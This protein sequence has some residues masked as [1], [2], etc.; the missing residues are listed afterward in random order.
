MK[1]GISKIH[2]LF[3]IPDLLFVPQRNPIRHNTCIV[4]PIELKTI[5][6]QISKAADLGGG[7]MK[8][9]YQM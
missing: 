8:V 7:G 1:T 6:L 5:M 2:V 4:F 3:V 9:T